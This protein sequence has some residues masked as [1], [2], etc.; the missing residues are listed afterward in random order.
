MA[1]RRILLALILFANTILAY[2]K[3]RIEIV[4]L[5][6]GSKQTLSTTIS[7]RSDEAI[8]A[9]D[10]EVRH[11]YTLKAEGKAFTLRTIGYDAKVIE[12]K[13]L[14]GFTCHEAYNAKGAEYR[15]AL[16]PKR[17]R[18]VT[19][20]YGDDPLYIYSI[21]DGTKTT[22]QIPSICVTFVAWASDAHAIAVT[23]N[24]RDS[25]SEYLGAVLLIDARTG[26]TEVIYRDICLAQGTG[27]AEVSRD[28][29][30]FAIFCRRTRDIRIVDLD[31][32]KLASTQTLRRDSVD[33]V[34]WS[35]DGRILAYMVPTAGR[36]DV[37]AVSPDGSI[38]STTSH[39]IHEVF[40]KMH[41]LD[42]NTLA[43][44]T[45]NLSGRLKYK[46]TPLKLDTGQ[47]GAEL[48]Y[49]ERSKI[50]PIDGGKKLFTIVSD[51]RNNLFS[52]ASA[53]VPSHPALALAL[54]IVMDSMLAAHR[55]PGASVGI[56]D[57][58][59][60]RVTVI[61]AGDA[62]MENVI[63]VDESQKV[64]ATLHVTKKETSVR[65][66]SYSGEVVDTKVLADLHPT[67]GNKLLRFIAYSMETNVFAYYDDVKTKAIHAIDLKTGEKN[68]IVGDLDVEMLHM[69]WID[70]K[71]ILL[72]INADWSKEQTLDN[73]IATL[74]LDTKKIV[75]IHKSPD[76]FLG[77]GP[78]SSAL[79]QKESFALS[80]DRSKFLFTR[81]SRI[82]D[83]NWTTLHTL[84][85]QTK[86][87]HDVMP[88]TDEVETHYAC[89]SA[90]GKEIAYLEQKRAPVPERPAEETA[91]LEKDLERLSKKPVL[92]PGEFQTL[93]KSL[94]TYA[95]SPRFIVTS[96]PKSMPLDGQPMK[97]LQ[98]IPEEWFALGFAP[99]GNSTFLLSCDE[100]LD[101]GGSSS[102]S[103]FLLS[104]KPGD[105]QKI[106]NRKWVTH[107]VPVDSGKLVLCHL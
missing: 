101:D 107:M 77:L 14:P 89:W 53:S 52:N 34:R 17:D 68:Q 103:V 27:A 59:N 70:P 31:K 86:Q 41:F 25:D 48:P 58:E 56:I 49:T 54:P 15:C 104:D 96:T 21:A 46:L 72:V 40:W 2:A 78:S 71:S 44:L 65:T 74:N 57:V 3:D 95:N 92:T 37:S 83:G 51:G 62:W 69:V 79:P 12:E 82:G 36:L 102:D 18:L 91:K 43:C 67:G 105:P 73:T 90:D 45:S 99:V 16:S 98:A 38:A 23:S 84:D 22:A 9:A 50:V 19:I 66:V 6:T 97:V 32:K 10:D 7:S 55:E 20:E 61:D 35:P 47:W 8:L 80:P 93:Q 13:P 106:V 42:S 85:L 33:F 26:Q 75:V 81:Q 11:V 30:F 1:N 39:E 87:V 60:G 100:N 88:Q 76:P 29:R 94:E 63:G 64:F 4:D 5:S 24:L 28:K